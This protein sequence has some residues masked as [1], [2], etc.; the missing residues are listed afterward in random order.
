MPQI[1]VYDKPLVAP[2]ALPGVRQSSVASPGMLS[3]QGQEA[4]RMGD[5]ISRSAT[6]LGR[7]EAEQQEKDDLQAVFTAEAGLLSEYGEFK[8]ETM[9]S[10][11]GVFS[12]GVGKDTAAWW[13]EKMGEYTGTM[14]ERQRV[15]LQQR[16]L[17]TRLSAVD[18]MAEF[19]T[20]EQRVEREKALTATIA[21]RTTDAVAA[22]G[23]S[24][25]VALMNDAKFAILQSVRTSAAVEGWHKY[26]EDEV[27]LA[28]LHN[29]HTQILQ[30]LA[31]DEGGAE[32]A[33]AYFAGNKGEMDMAKSEDLIKLTAAAKS[34]DTAAKAVDDLLGKATTEGEGLEWIRTNLEGEARDQARLRWKEHFADQAQA[35]NRTQTEYTDR[36]YSELAAKGSISKVDP[37]VLKNMDPKVLVSE[38][39]LAEDR[40]RVA[41][42]KESKIETDWGLYTDLRNEAIRDPAAFARKDMRQYLSRLAP[43][44]LEQVLDLQNQAAKPTAAG[45]DWRT[46]SQ[47]IGDVRDSVSWPA[48]NNG[49]EE[50][51][52]FEFAATQEV[53]KFVAQ[54][55]RE[56]DANE[57]NKIT[58][59][60]LLEGKVERP[61]F[62]DRSARMF[63]VLGTPDEAKFTAEI[64]DTDRAGIIG[65]FKKTRGDNFIPTEAQIREAFNKL[66]GIK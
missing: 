7:I 8:R 34:R 24:Q 18:S 59:R 26:R 58:G 29:F 32:K 47:R 48:G 12:K 56:P 55:N 33:A 35:V 19:E 39:R 22:V 2:D 3:Q 43:A 62:F 42:G 36:F 46:I 17:R 44:Q 57:L 65:A 27:T 25:E 31:A 11:R 14:P 37:L 15:A 63:E 49:K 66:K 41:S 52:K 28:V 38:R 60:L 64:P 53:D 30:R 1:P 13:N 61:Y 45:K 50:R 23:S 10:R 40:A 16:L 9:K 5:A 6:A 21:L 51:G 54:H 20:G 4:Q